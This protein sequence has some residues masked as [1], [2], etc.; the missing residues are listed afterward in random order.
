[1]YKVSDA[2]LVSAPQDVEVRAIHIDMH[3]K[4]RLYALFK[5]RVEMECYLWVI[6]DVYKR[7]LVSRLRMG[8]LPLRIETGRYEGAGVIGSR[9]IP[10]KFRVCLC[11][12]L[13]KVEDE[14]HFLLECPFF[15]GLR[16][17]LLRVCQRQLGQAVISVLMNDVQAFFVILMQSDNACVWRA[18]ADY[19][20]AAYQRRVYHLKSLHVSNVY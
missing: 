1:V 6:K 17:E 3:H 16:H 10:V 19:V 7:M 13:R 11:C 20:S 4:L 15:D 2:F 8:V 12:V 9:G 14:I 18:I 5:H